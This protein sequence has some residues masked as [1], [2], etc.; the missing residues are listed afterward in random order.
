VAMPTT[1]QARPF[2]PFTVTAAGT[3]TPI[4]PGIN[5]KDVFWVIVAVRSMG[6]SS[7]VGLGD[8]I[9]QE[10]RMYYANDFLVWDLPN[11]KTFN[12]ATLYVKS[13]NG[14]A[15]VEVSGMAEEAVFD[16][17]SIRG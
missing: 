14:D 15:V 4:F 17:S 7:W 2:T 12:A 3:P 11:G 13:E 16:P 1:L 5:R 6:T 9:A 8:S 10:G